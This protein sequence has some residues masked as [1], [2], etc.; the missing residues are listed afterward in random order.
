MR[1][2]GLQIKGFRRFADLKIKDI[3]ETARLVVLTGPNGSG[4]SSLFDAILMNYKMRTGYGYFSDLEYFLRR[5]SSSIISPEKIEFEEDVNSRTVESDELRS[6]NSD[7]IKVDYNDELKRGSVYVRTAHR[8]GADF[9]SNGITRQQPM[10]ERVV[11]NRMIDADSSIAENYARLAGIAVKKIF[12]EERDGQTVNDFR[13]DLLG[14]C[15]EPLKKLFEN[16]EFK[17]LGDP[18]EGGSFVFKKGE[19]E[20]FDYKN[21]SSGEKAAFDLILDFCIKREHFKDAIFCVDEPEVHINTKIQGAL[22][23]EL[24]ALLPEKCQ[25]W[26][27]SHSIGMMR[28]ARGLSVSKPG[29]V[30]FLDFSNH[31]YDEEVVITPSTPNRKFWEGVMTVALD[32]LASLLAPERIVL[33]EGMPVGGTSKRNAENDAVIYNLIFSEEYSHVKFISVGSSKEVVSDFLGVAAILPRVASGVEVSSLIDLDDHS[34]DEVTRYRDQNVLVL[35]RRHLEAYLYDDEILT[36]L[37]NSIGKAEKI[38]EVIAA[39]ANALAKNVERGKPSDDVKSAAAMIFS[40]IKIILGLPQAGSNQ[41]EFARGMLAPL[42]HPSTKVYKELR[43]C[44]FG[45]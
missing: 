40:Q 31:N 6:L 26:V 32:D 12:V 42:I 18:L 3:P 41:M 20:S 8:H 23:E 29:S 10:L 22:L 44:I 35:N 15:R 16:L 28:K 9:A 14:G 4:K 5:I 17:G 36:A 13:N 2:V 39:K 38:A 33:C 43:H 45:D 37:C 11:V 34:P 25:L 27:G 21:L 1:I 24:L 30:A 19:V 7:N